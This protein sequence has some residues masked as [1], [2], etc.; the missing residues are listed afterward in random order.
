MGWF[1]V[2]LAIAAAGVACFGARRDVMIRLTQAD[3]F[4]TAALALTASALAAFATLVLS[5]PGAERTTLV[6]R[7]TLAVLAIWAVTMMWA[8]LAAGRGLPIM[9]DRHWPACFARVVLVSFVPVMVLFGMA[10]RAAPLRLGWTGALAALAA[11]SMAA[12]AVQIVCPIDDAGHAFLGHFA[13]VVTITA[14]GAVVRGVLA[15]RAVGQL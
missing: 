10:R 1:V 3:Y 4:W 2:A 9:T 6:R 8:V 14:L 11:A 15:R 7:M 12:L 13:P 5:V